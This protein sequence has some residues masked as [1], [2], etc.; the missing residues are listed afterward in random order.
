GQPE[1]LKQ[2]DRAYNNLWN[3]AVSTVRQP[4]ESFFNW[5]NEKTNIQNAKKVRSEQGLLLHCFGKIAVA[6]MVLVFNY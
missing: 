1:C 6:L 3:T 2:R 5:L 4:V